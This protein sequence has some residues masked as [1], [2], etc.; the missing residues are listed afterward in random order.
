MPSSNPSILIL[1]WEYDGYNSPQTAALVKRPRY[2][3]ER[4]LEDGY[5]VTVL[6]QAAIEVDETITNPSGGSLRLCSVT[7]VPAPAAASSLIGKFKTFYELLRFGDYSG[8]WHQKVTEKV[9]SSIGK[10]DIVLAC[11]TPRGPLYSVYRLK[12]Q[13]QF[14][15]V[16]DLQ[17][18][19][20]EGLMHQ[21]ARMVL[22]WGFGRILRSAD[23]LFCVNKEWC[24]EIEQDFEVSCQY[25]PH[26]IEEQVPIVSRAFSAKHLTFL[27]SG[28]LDERF[29][30]PGLFAECLASL[31]GTSLIEDIEFRYAGASFKEQYFQDLLP[32]GIRFTYLG[33]LNREQLFQEI[34]LADV[35]CVFPITSLAY[36][37]CIPSKFYEYCRFGKPIALVGDDTGAFK[38]ELGSEFDEQ[39]VIRSTNSFLKQIEGLLSGNGKGFFMPSEN[40]LKRYS[41]DN[42]YQQLISSF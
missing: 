18:P 5:Q 28:S 6:F 22:K 30:Y 25:L 10:F 20:H 4:L 11:F 32:K 33:W 31:L 7:N 35:L 34:A 14:R 17:D 16:F 27:Y 39:F 38:D 37:T 40:F 21:S 23:V 8:R 1:C 3:A 29:Q 36:K 13:L 2:F 15:A 9:K 42:V 19:Y 26:V 12:K 24:R 41:L